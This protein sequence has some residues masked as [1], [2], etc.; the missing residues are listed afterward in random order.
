MNDKKPRIKKKSDDLTKKE[1]GSLH[2]QRIPIIVRK[3]PV[4]E[5]GDSSSEEHPHCALPNHYFDYMLSKMKTE[6]SHSRSLLSVETWEGRTV[7]SVET[8]DS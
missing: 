3:R 2:E 7:V 5:N 8:T 1:L 4:E 6:N